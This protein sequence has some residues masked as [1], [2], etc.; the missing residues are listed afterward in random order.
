M[1]GL[2]VDN[3]IA[4]EPPLKVGSGKPVAEH[5]DNQHVCRRTVVINDGAQ[6]PAVSKKKL[7]K[8]KKITKIATFNKRTLNDDW[9]AHGIVHHTR[10]QNISIIGLQEH[11]A[12]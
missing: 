11:I 3:K 4:I 5:C 7:L 12:V 9:R 1:K 8:A 6:V 10:Q 2:M